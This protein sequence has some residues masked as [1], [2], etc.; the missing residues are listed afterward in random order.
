MEK[1]MLIGLLAAV[2]FIV[3]CNAES[4]KDYIVNNRRLTSATNICTVVVKSGQAS[5]EAKLGMATAVAVGDNCD[6]NWYEYLLDP[7][8]NLPPDMTCVIDAIAE[9]LFLAD[10]NEITISA[11]EDIKIT[12]EMLTAARNNLVLAAERFRQAMLQYGMKE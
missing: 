12:D 11:V 5:P 7:E 10:A 3:G 4:R 9:L 1:I 2:M 6:K 8:H